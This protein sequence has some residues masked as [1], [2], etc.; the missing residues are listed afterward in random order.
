[1]K[2]ISVK[3]G[4]R[5]YKIVV[6]SDGLRKI[7]R[8]AEKLRL[9]PPLAVITDPTVRKHYGDTVIESLKKQGYSV[10]IFSIPGGEPCKNLDTVRD[11]YDQLVDLRVERRSAIIALGGGLVG[12]IAGFVA[13]TYLRG[14][15]FVQIP[16][17][18]LA[19][20][21]ASVG[22]KTGIDHRKGKNLIGA[23]HQPSMVVIDTNTLKTLPNREILCGLA[24]IVKHGVI[25]DTKIFKFVSEQIDDLLKIDE[26]AYLDLI[27]RN[28]RFKA[29]IV[30]QDERESGLRAI[31]NFGHTV[32]HAV[33]TLTGYSRYLHGE[34]V[35][36]G[37]LAEISVGIGMEITSEDLFDE[38]ADLVKR[39]GYPLDLPSV[40]GTQI[41]EAM[42]HDKKV[43]RQTIRMIIPKRL[44][45]V[46]IRDIRDP[47]LIVQ[48]WDELPDRLSG[49]K[50]F[51]KGKSQE[52][53][54]KSDG[55]DSASSNES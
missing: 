18:L 42:Y 43:Q 29:K 41:V 32:G 15:P 8:H 53:K 51:L 25:G 55:E 40:S 50:R 39:A 9:H 33:E 37:M 24:E 5:K 47:N 19:Q 20:V 27:P 12:D 7:G 16:T 23:F 35:A 36:I 11:L 3:L 48:A 28:C 22:G 1:M 26:E 21:D 10:G 4:E 44:G 38:V 14:I 6:E 46:E 49:K 54:P 13:A 17:T 45:Q 34:A 31:L 2:E 30:E 52:E